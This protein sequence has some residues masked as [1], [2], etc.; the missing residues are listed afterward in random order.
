[1]RKVTDTDLQDRSHPNTA[2]DEEEKMNPCWVLIVTQGLRV[3]L[4]PE[5]YL[6]RDTAL[7]EAQRWRATFDIPVE[8]PEFSPRSRA[9]QLFETLFPEP[10]RACPVWVGVSWSVRTYPRLRIEL[11]AADEHEAADWLRRRVPKAKYADRP[12]Q[13]E[14]ERREVRSSAGILRVKRVI[15]V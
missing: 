13:V 12:G 7:R 11:M 4:P 8:P 6:Q 3:W 1:M 10:W 9:L 5:V 14:F 15:G 2:A